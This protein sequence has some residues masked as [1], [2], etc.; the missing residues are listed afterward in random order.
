MARIDPTAVAPAESASAEPA[1]VAG[2]P[3][4]DIRG[5]ARWLLLA[6]AA[7]AVVAMLWP[8]GSGTASKGG[9]LVDAGGRPAPLAAELAPVTLLHFYASWCPPCVVEAPSLGRLIHDLA[10]ERRFRVVMVAVNDDPGR[11]QTLADSE[12]VLF[13]PNWEVAHRYGT[14]QLPESYLIVDGKTRRK[15]VGAVDWDDAQVREAI[16]RALGTGKR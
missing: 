3:Q 8:R 6:V 12:D 15:F 5:P 11:A 9:F 10:G 13:D 14:S 1:P 2:A 7:V 16:Q 4:A